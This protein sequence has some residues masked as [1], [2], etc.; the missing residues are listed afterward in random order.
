M[1]E[2]TDIIDPVSAFYREALS[3]MLNVKMTVSGIYNRYCAWCKECGHQAQSRQ[4]FARSIKI[5]IKRE[6]PA[7]QFGHSDK[8]TTITLMK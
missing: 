8:E 6:L 7:S 2:F 4:R 3:D 5:I 1:Q